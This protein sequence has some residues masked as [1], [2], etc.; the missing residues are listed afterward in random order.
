MPFG[1]VGI[2]AFQLGFGGAA[3]VIGDTGRLRTELTVSWRTA[4]VS[5]QY[6]ARRRAARFTLPAMTRF[7][8]APDWIWMNSAQL[9]EPSTSVPAGHG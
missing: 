9:V 3:N 1:Y 7:R 6:P 8:L 4:A 2:N 5:G